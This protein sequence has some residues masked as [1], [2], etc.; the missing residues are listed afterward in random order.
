[1]S[2]LYIYIHTHMEGFVFWSSKVAIP[3]F[4]L[5]GRRCLEKIE[6]GSLIFQEA[7][8]HAD[9]CIQ[10]GSSIKRRLVVLNC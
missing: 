6:L 10:T 3:E 2:L 7:N 5:L 4:E 8:A 9:F 1:M